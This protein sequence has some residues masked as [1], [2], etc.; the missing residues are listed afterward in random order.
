[1][2]ARAPDGASIPTS[3][4]GTRFIDGRA[5]EL[6]DERV[7][8]PC[9]H[10]ERRRHLLDGAFTHDGDAPAERHRLFLIVSH[11][12]NGRAER[13]VQP[14][15]LRARLRAE[16]GIEVG[17]RLIQQKRFRLSHD[18]PAERDALALAA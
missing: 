10:V 1:M 14:P 5:D 3:V 6:C 7:D 8:R 4:A 9:V 18:R 13:A 17:E 11:V 12:H 2:P 15:Q 16:R